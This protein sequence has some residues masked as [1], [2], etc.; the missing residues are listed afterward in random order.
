MIECVK[1]ASFLAPL[2]S[3]EQRQYAADREVQALHLALEV[4]PDFKRRTIQGKAAI[5]FKPVAKPVQ[6]IKLDAVKLDVG[7]VSASEKVQAYQV[8]DDKLIV[9]F[10]API[11]P[12]HEVTVTVAYSA[13]PSEGLYFRTPEMGYKEGD[14]HLFSQ[15]EEIEA[16]HWYPCLDSPNQRLTS[17]ITCRVPA[18]M[19]VVSNGRLVSAEKDPGTGLTAFHWSQE[20]SHAN[21]LVSLVAGSFKT[22]EDKYRDIPLGFYTPASEIQ[23]ADTSFRDTKDMMEFFEQETGIPFPWAKY[24]QVCVNDFV[25]GGMENTSATTLTDGTLF[26]AATENIRSSDGLIAHELA[27]QWFGDLVTCKDWSHIWLNEGFATYYETLYEEHK[28]GR[29]AMLYELY[30]RLRQITGITN[31]VTPIVRRNFD[32]PGDMFGYLVYPKAGWV[33]HMLR[34]QLGAELYRRCIK[35]YVERHQFGNV[36]SEDLRAVIEELSG[37]SFD[38]FFDQWLYHGH[39]PELEINYSWDETSKLAKLFIKQTQEL[40]PNV[41]LFHFPLTVRFKGKFGTNDSSVQ[42]SKKEE[43]FYF[44]L[45]SAPEL[46]RVDPEFTLLAKIKF[47]PPNAMLGVQLAETADVIGRLL[48]VEQ[49]SSKRDHESVSKLGQTLRQDPFY[50]VRLE[51]SKA[52]HAIHNDEALEALLASDKQSDARVRLQVVTD[53]GGFYDDKAYASQRKTLESEKNP[54]IL[55]S[56]TRALSGYSKPEV[57]ETLIKVL[58]SESYRNELA[59][60]A[61]AGMRLEDDP[62]VIPQLLTVLD[63]EETNFTSNGYAQ[64]LQALAYLARNQEKKDEVREFLQARVNH[65]KRVVQLACISALGTLGDPKAIPVLQGFAAASKATPQRSAAERAVAEL[66]AGRKPVDDFKNLRQEVLD[67]QKA[68]RDLQRQLDDL[69]KKVDARQVGSPGGTRSKMSG[70]KS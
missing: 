61:I 63:Q 64:G 3:P 10:A 5:R 20:K 17:E 28:R 69:K 8:T 31:D 18:G 23:Q 13:E 29:D 45:T 25:A 59:T 60:A 36:V 70:P 6:E 46:I 54:D 56:A 67:L 26:T 57:N 65:K 62:D 14:T 12:D 49:L 34:S 50:G 30:Q 43:D 24:D 40:G 48:V 33:L 38:Q 44:S 4:T 2:D 52:L 53:I 68:N 41:L 27:H 37:R 22:I 58:H 16:R 11:P 9:T 19:T 66:R 7:S 1:S 35:T 51:A 42:V 15:G 39:H 21:Y 32:K 47:E 55:S